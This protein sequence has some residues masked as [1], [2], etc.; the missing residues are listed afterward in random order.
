MLP[1]GN[2]ILK[3]FRQPKA[4]LE[5][6]FH[7]DVNLAQPVVVDENK[8]LGFLFRHRV[9]SALMLPRRAENQLVTSL[10][11]DT[12]PLADRAEWL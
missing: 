12:R 3:F 4:V 11:C 6:G 2:Q 8:L 9:I 1:E 7:I 10:R 5:E